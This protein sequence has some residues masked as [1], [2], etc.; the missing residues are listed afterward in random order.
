MS[1]VSDALISLMLL[2]RSPDDMFIVIVAPEK[3]A[4]YRK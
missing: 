1:E 4:D 2:T 3:K